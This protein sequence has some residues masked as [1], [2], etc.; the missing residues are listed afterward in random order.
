[1]HVLSSLEC[2]RLRIECNTTNK[3]VKEITVSQYITSVRKMNVSIIDMDRLL[4]AFELRLQQ[5][6]SY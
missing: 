6:I 5:I 2:L 4:A 1:M 3:L